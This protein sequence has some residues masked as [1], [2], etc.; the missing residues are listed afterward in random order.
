[1]PAAEATIAHL[2]VECAATRQEVLLVF[3][4]TVSKEMVEIVQVKEIFVFCGNAFA[5]FSFCIPVFFSLHLSVVFVFYSVFVCAYFSVV[6]VC[7][8]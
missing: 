3:V 4:M 8:G 1:M 2:W 6:G 5:I 7:R